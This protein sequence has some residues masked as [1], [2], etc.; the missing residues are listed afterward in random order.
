M[1]ALSHCRHDMGT[2]S[3]LAKMLKSAHGHS[4]MGLRYNVFPS[5]VVKVIFGLEREGRCLLFQLFIF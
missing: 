5:E 2:L 3:W 4:F 1:R